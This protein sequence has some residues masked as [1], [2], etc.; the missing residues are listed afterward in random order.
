MEIGCLHM[1]KSVTGVRIEDQNIH[2]NFRSIF[3]EKTDSNNARLAK[4][5]TL[6]YIQIDV[7]GNHG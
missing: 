2:M 1:A 6:I 4:M 7:I 5:R 3:P